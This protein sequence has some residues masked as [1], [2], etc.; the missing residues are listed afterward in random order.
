MTGLI[1]NR[2]ALAHSADYT[3]CPELQQA[4]VAHADDR[5]FNALPLLKQLADQEA[6][7]PGSEVYRILPVR[8]DRKPITLRRL[9][10]PLQEVIP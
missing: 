7:E 1:P 9:L 6:Q 4:I 3:A 2:L 5:Y 10:R 8:E